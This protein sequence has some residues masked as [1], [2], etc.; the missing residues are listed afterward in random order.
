M[1]FP[2]MA[3]A[4]QTLLTLGFVLAFLVGATAQLLPCSMSATGM[5]LHSDVMAGCAGPN[6]P[7]TDRA[8]ACVDRIG[9]LTVPAHPI[10]P[11]SLP[12]VFPWTSIAYDFA[13]V[14]LPGLSVEPELSP[15]ILAA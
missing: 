8:P 9:C 7:C 2:D 13:A 15:P 4:V 12:T 10:L 14:L 3:R 6:T 1:S 5:G 11:E